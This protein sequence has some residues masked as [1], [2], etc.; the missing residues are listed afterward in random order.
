MQNSIAIIWV[1][2]V[3]ERFCKLQSIWHFDV[4]WL[5][6]NQF[7]LRDLKSVAFLVMKYVDLITKCNVYYKICWYT[8]KQHYTFVLI[9][10]DE[11]FWIEMQKGQTAQR[12]E[13]L[14]TGELPEE[15]RVKTIKNV[16]RGTPYSMQDNQT[17]FQHIAMTVYFFVLN[18]KTRI[19]KDHSL[20]LH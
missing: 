20:T 6:S 16:I 14:L 7:S 18:Y 2:F 17:F 13:Y 15:R 12:W 3:V 19:G 11:T 1:F 9:S 5:I 4:N 10:I 8:V